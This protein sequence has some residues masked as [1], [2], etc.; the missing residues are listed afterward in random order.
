M[1]CAISISLVLS[2]FFLVQIWRFR[3]PVTEKLQSALNQ[4]SSVLKTTNQGLDVIDQ[5]INNIYS[6]TLYLDETTNALAQ[7]IRSTNLFIDSAGTF[8]GED[9]INTITN[10]QRTLNSAKSSALVIDN[11]MSTLSRVPLIGINYNPSLPLNIAL[12]QVSD[13]LDPFQGS[14]KSFQ[15]NLK[16]TQKNMQLF[17]DQLA[18]LGQNIKAINKNLAS[19]R[20]VIDKYRTQI[21]AYQSSVDKAKNSLQTWVNTLCWILTIIILWLVLI[22]IGIL[23]QGINSVDISRGAP[24]VTGK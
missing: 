2:L 17:N 7:T 5:A 16:S 12:G 23:L 8:L 18:I 3:H 4:T 21:T 1:V 11:I 24:D 13:S 22:Q 10:T 14:L 6:S 9:L 20:A 15:V 19:S